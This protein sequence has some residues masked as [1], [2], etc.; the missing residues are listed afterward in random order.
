MTK[1]LNLTSA[2]GWRRIAAVPV[3]GLTAVG[4]SATERYLLILSHDG[5]GVLETSTGQRVARD[6]QSPQHDASWIKESPRLVEG[7]PPIQGEWI[8]TVGL[9]GGSLP[10][11]NS[12][13]WS[14][15]REMGYV[16]HESSMQEFL[17]DSAVTEMRAFGFSNSGRFLVFASSS[18]LSLYECP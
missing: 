18:E 12:A 6:R 3:G 13:G 10:S 7:L 17:V 15:G 9:W 2:P 16:R 8:Q 5:R 11:R 14:V 1:T 4:F